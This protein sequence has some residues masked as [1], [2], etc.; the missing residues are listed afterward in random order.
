MLVHKIHKQHPP[1]QPPDK[2]I[3]DTTNNPPNDKFVR[4]HNFLVLGEKNIIVKD[5]A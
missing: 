3:S 2:E 4:V 1:N 5:S